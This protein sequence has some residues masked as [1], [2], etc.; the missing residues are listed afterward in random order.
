MMKILGLILLLACIGTIAH[1][2]KIGMTSPF[3]TVA[4]DVS[5]DMTRPMTEQE[6]DQA[7]LSFCSIIFPDS[8][9]SVSIE[10]NRLVISDNGTY[11][12]RPDDLLSTAGLLYSHLDGARK[13]IDA[14]P[15]RFEI[16]EI[17]WFTHKQPKGDQMGVLAVQV[18][19]NK[20]STQATSDWLPPV[21]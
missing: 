8:T 17:R 10:G 2:E 13:V 5:P 21:T 18:D 7:I 4:N 20:G 15:G 14:Y 19:K 1:A 12:T 6:K 16:V 11:V 9:Q 3:A